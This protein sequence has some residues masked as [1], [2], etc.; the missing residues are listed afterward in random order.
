MKLIILKFFGI[1][2]LLF[3]PL[4]AADDLGLQIDG[5]IG[6]SDAAY[7]VGADQD[8]VITSGTVL[9]DGEGRPLARNELYPGREATVV[10]ASFG[11]FGSRPVATKVIVYDA[12]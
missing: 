11:E 4:V 12:H 6:V 9:V 2:C 8:Y 3:G 5:M 10:S 1:C 7:V